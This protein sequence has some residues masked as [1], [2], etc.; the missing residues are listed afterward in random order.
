MHFIVY[1]VIIQNL[2]SNMFRPLLLPSSGWC[3]YYKNTKAEMWL[4]VSAPL[5]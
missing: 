4:A 3:Y 5:H 2:L 1:D